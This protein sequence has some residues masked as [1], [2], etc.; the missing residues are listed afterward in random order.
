MLAVLECTCAAVSFQPA[1]TNQLA[2]SELH[3]HAQ[4]H[5]HLLSNYIAFM[6]QQTVGLL[7]MCRNQE[8]GSPAL[9][10]CCTGC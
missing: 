2:R 5:Q 7:D 4:Q 10:C 9:A 3:A 6:T 8:V 1:K